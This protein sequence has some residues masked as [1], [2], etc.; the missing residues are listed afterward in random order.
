MRNAT[1]ILVVLLL[2]LCVAPTVAQNKIRVKARAV[3]DT[4]T[5][6]LKSNSIYIVDPFPFEWYA[7]P[8]AEITEGTCIWSADERPL[9][10]LSAHRAF[11]T[12]TS[13]CIIQIKVA[14]LGKATNDIT[15]L[16]SRKHITIALTNEWQKV[17][18]GKGT[19]TQLYSPG[20]FA[21]IDRDR[22]SSGCDQAVDGGRLRGI[23][24]YIDATQGERVSI[25]AG[26]TAWYRILTKACTT[27]MRAHD[28]QTGTLTLLKLSNKAIWPPK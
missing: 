26:D 12:L 6:D 18:L 3:G 15:F 4:F 27:W 13:G 25:L 10:R 28:G 20:V 22:Y 24:S 7:T 23:S 19:Y 17:K 14:K 9:D 8:E 21:E 1:F 11:R 5:I 16:R 2:C